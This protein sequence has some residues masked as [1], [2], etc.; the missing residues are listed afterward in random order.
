MVWDTFLAIFYAKAHGGDTAYRI[1]D[2]Q[3]REKNHIGLAE[4]AVV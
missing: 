1:G 4:I 2:L 3:D